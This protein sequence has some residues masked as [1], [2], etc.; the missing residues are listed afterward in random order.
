MKAFVLLRETLVRGR[1]LYA[2]DRPTSVGQNWESGEV[3]PGG[4]RLD[5]FDGEG[6]RLRS[7]IFFC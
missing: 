5:D 2:L 4:F 7:D 6:E 1:E 3:D